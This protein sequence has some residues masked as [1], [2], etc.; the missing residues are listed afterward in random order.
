[1]NIKPT[2][3]ATRR[4]VASVQSQD[5]DATEESPPMN[6]LLQIPAGSTNIAICAEIQDLQ[7]FRAFQAMRL[8]FAVEHADHPVIRRMHQNDPKF[9]RMVAEYR[10]REK[11]EAEAAEKGE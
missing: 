8:K 1:M 7:G 5:A 3:P 11:A 4:Q 6:Q 9:W 10:A 2:R